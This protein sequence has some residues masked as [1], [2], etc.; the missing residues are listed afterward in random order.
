[1]ISDLGTPIQALGY[2]QYNRRI[3]AVIM[4]Q[5]CLVDELSGRILLGEV[6]SWACRQHSH[7]QVDTPLTVAEDN[8]IPAI[9]STRLSVEFVARGQTATVL[10]ARRGIV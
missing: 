3:G 7:V 4:W 5:F 9:S 2:D 8:P 10:S 1:M 6:S